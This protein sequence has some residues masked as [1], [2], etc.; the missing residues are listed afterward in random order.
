MSKSYAVYSESFASRVA[1]IAGRGLKLAAQTVAPELMTYAGK[2]KSNITSVVGENKDPK[3][4]VIQYFKNNPETFRPDCKI[5]KIEK[6]TVAGPIQSSTIEATK[7]KG[8]YKC[9]FSGTVNKTDDLFNMGEKS[10]NYSLTVKPTAD[11]MYQVDQKIYKDGELYSN[12]DT[13][14]KVSEILSVLPTVF[15]QNNNLN[16]KYQL[17][18]KPEFNILGLVDSND[19]S[20]GYKITFKG[21]A[22]LASGTTAITPNDNYIIVTINT[23]KLQTDGKLY[24]LN[25]QNQLIENQQVIYSQKNIIFETEKLVDLFLK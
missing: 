24:S 15:I 1:G 22:K 20:K 13:E 23:G 21:T 17:D 3:D 6:D 11:K 2:I 16:Q 19:L 5:I 25:Q 7:F 12:I 4:A 9:I 14:I 10:D 8:F 18:K